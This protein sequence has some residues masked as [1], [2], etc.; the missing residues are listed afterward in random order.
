LRSGIAPL[1]GRLGFTREE[2]ANRR[3]RQLTDELHAV[4]REL[5]SGFRRQL[6]VREQNGR[7]LIESRGSH[8]VERQ[9]FIQRATRDLLR[10]PMRGEELGVNRLVRIA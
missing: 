1:A 3:P 4:L 5:Q 8:V 7:T 10:A 6:H 9:H 2:A